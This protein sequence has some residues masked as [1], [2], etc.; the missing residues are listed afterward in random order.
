MLLREF[1][2]LVLEIGTEYTELSIQVSSRK[3]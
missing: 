3:S 1:L 2:E